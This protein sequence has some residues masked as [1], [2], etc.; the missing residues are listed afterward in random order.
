MDEPWKWVVGGMILI[1]LGMRFAKGSWIKAIMSGFVAP[2]LL[3]PMFFTILIGMT[4][5]AKVIAAGF[6]TSDQ[7][8]QVIADIALSGSVAVTIGLF[9]FYCIWERQTIGIEVRGVI[10][11]SSS[12][13][14]RLTSP[15]ALKRRFG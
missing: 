3:V 10:G 13:S 2:L 14:E 6:A 5:M 11:G 12:G 9:I 1:I 7:L 8:A 15:H 4:C